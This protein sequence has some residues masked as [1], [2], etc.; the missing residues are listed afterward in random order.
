MTQ[1]DALI[2]KNYICDF[3]KIKVEDPN[4]FVRNW[5]EK[6]SLKLENRIF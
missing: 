3:Q 1:H 5:D 6:I 2:T 4:F